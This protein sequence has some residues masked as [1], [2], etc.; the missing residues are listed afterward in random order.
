MGFLI[1][2]VHADMDET[3]LA[4]VRRA[5]AKQVMAW[6][7]VS[8]ARIEAAFAS[9]RREDFLGAGPWQVARWPNKTPKDIPRRPMLTPSISTPMTCLV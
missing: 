8:N 6:A 2:P 7:G 5:Y 3:D 4:I 1:S 9:I